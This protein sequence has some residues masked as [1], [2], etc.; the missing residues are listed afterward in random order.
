M[1]TKEA[2][3]DP[4]PE[5]YSLISQECWSPITFCSG[6]HII[7]DKSTVKI[8]NKKKKKGSLPKERRKY[9]C[10]KLLSWEDSPL[11]LSLVY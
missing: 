11:K 3:P 10:L 2:W 7:Y 9:Y 4:V 1:G 5:P 8:S 6:T